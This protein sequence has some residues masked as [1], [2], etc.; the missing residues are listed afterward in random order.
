[1]IIA[2]FTLSRLVDALLA[3]ASIARCNRNSP[4]HKRSTELP[5]LV[6]MLVVKL[7]N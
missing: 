7:P 3:V 1:M 2:L 4:W 6:L 5:L